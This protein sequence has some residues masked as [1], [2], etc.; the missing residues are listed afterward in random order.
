MDKTQKLQ[1]SIKQLSLFT[2]NEAITELHCNIFVNNT[3][4]TFLTFLSEN[5]QSC[6]KKFQQKIKL[7]PVEIELTTD[8]HW[9]RNLM[10][11]HLC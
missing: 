11:I 3:N 1:N 2:D 8:H 7:L 5:W 9:F 4:S 10:F 6:L